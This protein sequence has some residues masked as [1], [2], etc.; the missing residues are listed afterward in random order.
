MSDEI[1]IT[2]I[3]KAE[4]LAA[5]YNEA[6]PVGYGRLHY[7]PEPMTVEQARIVLGTATKEGEWAP[8][9]PSNIEGAAYCSAGV[10]RF[11]YIKGRSIKVEFAGNVLR[12]ADLYD[13]DAG[14][15]AAQRIVNE[16]RA[17]TREQ[18]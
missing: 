8:L 9:T 5:L 13:R 1:D 3:D 10:Y 18:P 16:V 4:L 2:G 14:P 17:Q 15:G 11:D 12:R 7:T 6:R